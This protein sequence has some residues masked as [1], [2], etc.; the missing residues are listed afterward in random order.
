[1][2]HS[3]YKLPLRLDEII[4]KKKLQ[5]CSLTHSIAQNLHLIISTYRGEAAYSDEFGCSLWDEEFNIQLNFNWKETLIE[6]LKQAVGKFEKRLQLL[7]V[8]VLL[9]EQN[10]LLKEGNLRIRKCLH[11]EIRGL[12]KKTNEP[13]NFRDIIFISPLAQK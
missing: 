5:T 1:M 3:F 7:D 13:F 10:E 6:S 2:Q 9:Q 8:K 11:I 12:I 4:Q